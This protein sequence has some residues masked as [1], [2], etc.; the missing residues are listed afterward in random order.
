LHRSTSCVHEAG[1]P[2]DAL[3][4]YIRL[5]V[6]VAQI[7]QGELDP[8]ITVEQ[9][10]RHIRDSWTNT[11]DRKQRVLDLLNWLSRPKTLGMPIELL[12]HEA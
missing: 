3:D 12:R 6:D 9:V 5:Y 8:K 1:S 7:I 10:D 4:M 11:P 2:E